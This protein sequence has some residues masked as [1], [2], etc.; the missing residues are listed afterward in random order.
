M[1][2]P[3]RFHRQSFGMSGSASVE[4][5]G[6][7]VLQQRCQS[8][9]YWG[10]PEKAEARSL[11]GAATALKWIPREDEAEKRKGASIIE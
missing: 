11:P 4:S 10:S 7:E 6:P 5:S 8:R 3:F 2:H 9:S 1:C